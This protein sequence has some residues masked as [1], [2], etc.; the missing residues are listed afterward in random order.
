MEF[1]LTYR[2]PL[3]ANGNLREKQALRRHFHAQLR[4]LWAQVPLN[5]FQ[6]FL[7]DPP[8]P[9]KISL[10]RQV[11][12]FKFAP[13]VSPSLGLVVELAITFL[14]PEA[15]GSLVTQAGDI[16]NRLKTLFDALRMPTV[17]TEIPADDVPLEDE[18]PFFCLLEDD[19]LITKISVATDRLLEVCHSP[20]EV[21]LLLQVTTKRVVIPYGA[22]GLP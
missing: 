19:N 9:S 5:G 21:I 13:L 17:P 20:T 1:T 7:A 11:Q 16:D 2:G 6:Q 18:T 8:I 4:V 15:P 22:I 14:R 12:S 10:L 3:K